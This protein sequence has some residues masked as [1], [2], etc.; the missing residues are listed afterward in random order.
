MRIQTN[1]SK[2]LT[3]LAA[4]PVVIFS[5]MA[6]AQPLTLRVSPA[7][8][9]GGIPSLGY[10]VNPAALPPGVTPMGY[11][12]NGWLMVPADDLHSIGPRYVQ[13][14]GIKLRRG[15][16]VPDWIDTGNMES[17]SIRGLQSSTRYSYFISPDQ[18]I[19]VM[20]PQSRR[21]MR[22]IR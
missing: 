14:S 18:K 11:T 8:P 15:S 19:V 7:T 17:V 3:A 6:I 16:E 9:P 4:A 5:S 22:V 13:P 21:V 1:S 20:D 10:A 12:Q 2:W